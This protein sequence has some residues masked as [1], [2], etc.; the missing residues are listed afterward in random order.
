MIAGLESTGMSKTEIAQRLG[1]S[2]STIHRVA[3][4]QHYD[5]KTSTVIRLERILRLGKMSRVT[6]K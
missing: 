6:Q 3:T 5:H 2:R 4:N 1:V